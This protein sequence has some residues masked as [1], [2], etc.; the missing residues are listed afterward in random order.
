MDPAASEMEMIEKLD[1][2]KQEV[3]SNQEEFSILD[4][5]FGQKRRREE[6]KI[7]D[8]IVKRLVPE[9][10]SQALKH[11]DRKRVEPHACV[12]QP[13]RTLLPRMCADSLAKCA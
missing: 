3:S 9:G 10:T 13:D 7:S 6:S 12:L 5:P 1:C 4:W 8:G 2:E 11:R